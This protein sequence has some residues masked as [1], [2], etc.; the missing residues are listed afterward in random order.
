VSELFDAHGRRLYLTRDERQ[1]VLAA[2]EVAERRTRTFC[3][4]LAY[5]GCR[6]S[7]A[8]ALT[9]GRVDL[10]GRALVFETLKKRRRGVYRAVPVPPAV[11]DAL[12][13]VHG[14]REAQRRRNGGHGVRLWP[15]AR[16]TAWLRL[17]GV[18]RAAGIRGGPHATAK[19]FRHGFGVAAVQAGIPLNLVQRWLGHAQLSTTAIYADAL[20]AEEQSIA[21]RMWL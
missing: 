15:W 4:T 18:M 5:T 14:V 1:A 3:L 9:C 12:D 13:L 16:S 19:G 8:L 7:E 21:A 2:A 6:I 11:L 10:A 17:Q 20:G